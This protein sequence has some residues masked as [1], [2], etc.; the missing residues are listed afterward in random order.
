MPC[1]VRY[2]RNHP[3][4]HALY[5]TCKTLFMC[6]CLFSL[7]DFRIIVAQFNKVT[8]KTPGQVHHFLR[9]LRENTW[10]S[11]LTFAKKVISEVGYFAGLQI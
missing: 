9:V 10:F 7:F 4:Y 2:F 11:K 6:C 5:I 3:L 1:A 8:L